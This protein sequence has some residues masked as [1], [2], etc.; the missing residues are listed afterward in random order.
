MVSAEGLSWANSQVIN[1]KNRF[2]AR[3]VDR[4]FF[5]G[6]M[7][8][9]KTTCA[10]NLVARLGWK[11]IELDECVEALAGKPVRRIFAEDGEAQFRRLEHEALRQTVAHPGKTL[12][13]CGGGIVCNPLNHPLLKRTSYCILL[14][15]SSES[16]F[17][18]LRHK[19]PPLLEVEDPM[20]RIVDLVSERRKSYEQLADWVYDTTGQDRQQVADDVF[21]HIMSLDMAYTGG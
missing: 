4:V 18:R 20:T 14:E 9:G 3:A 21:E 19:L 7:G 5:I 2:Q 1:L 16:I 13:S 12:V 6:F 17:E 11:R 10:A 8:V 15:A